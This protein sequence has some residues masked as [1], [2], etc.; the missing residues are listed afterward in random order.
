MLNIESY[1]PIHKKER[2]R[3]IPEVIRQRKSNNREILPVIMVW[4][5]NAII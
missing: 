4:L 2:K 5:K 3:N 1:V